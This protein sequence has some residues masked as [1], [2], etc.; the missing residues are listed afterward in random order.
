MTPTVETK[1]LFGDV[2]L[3]HDLVD[4]H[5]PLLAAL[6]SSRDQAIDASPPPCLEDIFL[7]VCNIRC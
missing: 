6:A 4:S 2:L 3:S 1:T 7:F 5:T